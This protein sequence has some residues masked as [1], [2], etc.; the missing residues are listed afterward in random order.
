MLQYKKGGSVNIFKNI[1]VLLA[2]LLHVVIFIMESFLFLNEAVYSRFLITSSEQAQTIALFAYNQGWYNLF[3]AL[4]AL[5]GLCFAKSLPRNVGTSLCV[6]ACLSMLGA[7]IVLVYSEPLLARAAF[8]QG[9][10]PATALV[11]YWFLRN[12]QKNVS[13]NNHK[14]TC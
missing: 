2:G 14:I 10:F 3:L 7:A 8:I 4:G 6:Y 9:I 13:N 1:M 5:I 11:L 12:K